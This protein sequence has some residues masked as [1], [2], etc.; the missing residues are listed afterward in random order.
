[1]AIQLAAPVAEAEFAWLVGSVC[2]INRLPFD[3]ALRVHARV[4]KEALKAGLLCYPTGGTADGVRGDHVL[5]APPF[6]V[7]EAQ[8]VELVDKLGGALEATLKATAAA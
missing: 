3:P 5:L 1:M 6:I 2:Q 8:L 4:K 7:E